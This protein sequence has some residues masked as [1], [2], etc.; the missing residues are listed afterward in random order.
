MFMEA[1]VDESD[2]EVG[3]YTF[4][5]LVDGVQRCIDAGR[6]EPHDATEMA[7]Q[8]WASAHG[9]LALHLAGMIDAERVDALTTH[10]AR[11][12]C[13]AFGDTPERLDASF[14]RAAE[15]ILP[16]LEAATT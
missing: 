8:L 9:V 16:R 4:Q 5:M 15:W 11:A 6:F 12:L 7:T 13:I 2:A 3:L 14:D 1:P 10:M